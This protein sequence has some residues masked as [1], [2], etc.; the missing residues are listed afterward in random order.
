MLATRPQGVSKG[1]AAVVA[2]EDFDDVIEMGKQGI[3]LVVIEHPLG[4]NPAATADDAG[5]AALH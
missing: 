1:E 3:L 4:Q 5:E 2:L